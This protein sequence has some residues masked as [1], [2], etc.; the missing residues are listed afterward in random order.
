M[1]A[2]INTPAEEKAWTKAKGIVARQRKKKES[3]FEDR[4]WALTTHIAKNILNASANMDDGMVF[5]LARVESMLR[6]RKNRDS[7]VSASNQALL[8]AL[9]QVAAVSGKA[10]AELRSGNLPQQST[11][12][13]T[14]ELRATA[15]KLDGLLQQLTTKVPK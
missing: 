4:D 3:D 13:L 14:N 6:A 11:D 15:E 1:P 9:S 7:V 8:S 5:A 12:Q 2:W 10:V